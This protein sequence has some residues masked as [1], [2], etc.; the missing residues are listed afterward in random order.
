MV[1]LT[2]I[3]TRGGDKG[4]TSLGDGTRV[5]KHSRRVELLGTVDEANAVVGLSRLYA[6]DDCDA[7][8]ARVQNELFD[9]GADLCVPICDKKTKVVLR[10]TILLRLYLLIV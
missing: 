5:S 2:R 10:I 9:I 8:L 3:Y 1:K 7:I 6:S 4:N